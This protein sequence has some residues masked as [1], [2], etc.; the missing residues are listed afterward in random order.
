MRLGIVVTLLALTGLSFVLSGCGDGMSEDE[1][2][3]TELKSGLRILDIREGRGEG[4]SKGDTIEFNYVGTFKLDGKEFERSSK[5][6]TFKLGD[7]QVINGWDEGLVG[8]K[9][10]GKRKLWIPSALAYGPN[11]TP[12]VPGNT[13]VIFE[14]DLLQINPEAMKPL[15]P[16]TALETLDLVEGT[17]PVATAGKTVTVH[18][19]GTLR[20]NGRKFD[21]SLDRGEPFTFTLGQGSVIKGWDEG[22]AGMKVGGK[23][24]LSIPARLGYGAR[25]A[26]TDIPP[27]ADL[28][29]EVELLDV[30]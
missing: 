29:F 16:L 10:G 26:G 9:M 18:Y 23:R 12:K 5:P 19:T 6:F 27:N 24:K 15:P 13:D 30:K 11:G 3:A 14:V 20:S 4:A 17:G 8:M 2:K 21:S 7:G 22:V 1:R 25:G 28:V